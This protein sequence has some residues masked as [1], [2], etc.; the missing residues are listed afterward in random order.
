MTDHQLQEQLLNA[1]LPAPVG[2]WEQ[3]NTVLDE[4]AEDVHFQ[5]QLNAIEI[6]VPVD[7]WAAIETELYWQQQD[8]K[9]A[10]TLDN[11]QLQPPPF[12][13]DNVD[14]AINET[15]DKQLAE[16]LLNVQLEAPAA[17]WPVIEEALHPQAKVIPIGKRFSPF[18]RY[19][20]AAVVIGLMAWG[21]F[22]LFNRS[23]D[24]VV[25]VNTPQQTVEPV[26]TDTNSKS[27]T[28]VT[29]AEANI[30]TTEVPE[31]L[32]AVNTPKKR[33]PVQQIKEEVM[34]H[35]R[36]STKSAE[37]SETNYL[38]VVDDK[39]DLIRVSKKLSTMD[40]VKNSDVPVD[41]V[42]ALQVKDCENKIKKLQQRL[43]TSVLGSVFDPNALN[44]ETEK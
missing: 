40:C 9:L 11:E 24:E 17:V 20:A 36:P 8:T 44:T 31:D 10:A 38:L 1:E 2:V 34:A 43:A 29:L 16:K 13:W 30:K 33:N 28:T 21:A 15:N 37:F 41:A 18:I 3:I 22:Q 32:M 27:T 7:A 25:A 23:K 4:D 19:A 14:A 12:V 26:T 5:K 39:G 6:T 35:E 42:T